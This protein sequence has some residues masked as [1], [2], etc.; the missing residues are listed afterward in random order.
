ML[1]M[2]VPYLITIL[3]S[4]ISSF[5]DSIPILIQNIFTIIQK[6]IKTP[7]LTIHP[8][9]LKSIDLSIFSTRSARE[10]ALPDSGL[11][12]TTVTPASMYLNVAS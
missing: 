9:S 4:V 10:A 8:V 6:T 11:T 2:H 5:S 1:E 12:R 3:K 7:M